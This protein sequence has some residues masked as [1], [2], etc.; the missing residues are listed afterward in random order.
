MVIRIPNSI[1]SSMIEAAYASIPSRL[2][3]Y[4]SHVDFFCGTDPIWAGLIQEGSDN[5]AKGGRS[6]RD[7]WCT[8]YSHHL[9]LPKDKCKTTIMIP[10]LSRYERETFWGIYSICHELGHVLDE[11]LGWVHQTSPITKYAHTSREE[12][13]AE[14]FCYWLGFYTEGTLL[15]IS[16]TQTVALFNAL[17]AG[18][19]IDRCL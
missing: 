4:L 19:A 18:N 3:S 8:V 2:A 5:P 16:N 17:K 9:L 13:F 6:F 15:T 14:M 7:T 12:A 1:V 11:K 10:K